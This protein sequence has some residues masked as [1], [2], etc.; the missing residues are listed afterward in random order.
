MPGFVCLFDFVVVFCLLMLRCLWLTHV[1]GVF[2]LLICFAVLISWLLGLDL[3]CFSL[4]LLIWDWCRLVFSLI[5]VGL[6]VVL[7]VVVWLVLT[8]I[9]LN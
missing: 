5:W 8:L 7:I 3:F 2:C 1:C 9:C 4:I 6:I